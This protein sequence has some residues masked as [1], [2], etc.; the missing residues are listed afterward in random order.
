MTSA[1]SRTLAGEME[2]LGVGVSLGGRP[3]LRDLT[4]TL[5]PGEVTAL[6]GPNGAGKS[7]CLRLLTRVMLPDEGRIRLAGKELERWSRRDLARQLAVV[8]QESMLP[9]GFSVYEL[10]M[11]GR[12]PYI[13][14][15][16][17]EGPADLRAVTQALERVR[18]ETL[19]DRRIEQLSGGER[20]R[21]VLARALAQTP[22]WLLLDEPTNNLDIRHQVDILRFVLA[23]SRR[24]LGVLV[25]LHDLNLAARVADRVLLMHDGAVW[26][27]GS[28]Q[29]VLTED[30]LRSVYEADV[31]V[32]RG[33]DGLPVML[34]VMERVRETLDSVGSSVR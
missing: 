5:R 27:D 3:I 20:Q 21:V 18:A 19:A 28:P 29:D 16:G 7:T 4:M 10:V 33:P 12:A 8:P 15:L 1:A 17:S 14:L 34:P 11:M 23:E 13:G 32:H 30:A 9:E 24:G 6:V 22:S 25:V 26:A 31:G 2:L